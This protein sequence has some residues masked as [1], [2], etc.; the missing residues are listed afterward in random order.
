LLNGRDKAGI[1]QFERHAHDGNKN[2]GNDEIHDA[3]NS[4][5]IKMIYRQARK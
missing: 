4:G 5:I 2:A 3:L 1:A